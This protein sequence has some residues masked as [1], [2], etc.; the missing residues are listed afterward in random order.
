MQVVFSMLDLRD[1]SLLFEEMTF[2]ESWW[3]DAYHFFEDTIV[4]Q[5]YEDSNDIEQKT[6][7]ALNIHDH[8]IIWSLDKV[9]ATGRFGHYL[10]LKSLEAGDVLF[11][12]DVRNGETFSSAPENINDQLVSKSLKHP[13]LYTEESPFF[14]TI[15]AFGTKKLGKELVKGCHYLEH[16]ELVIMA[17]QHEA[18]EAV[19]QELVVLDQTSTI[20]LERVLHHGDGGLV[21]DAFFIAH[22]QLIFVEGK[23]TLNG[24]RIEN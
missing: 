18:P 17:Y 24:F 3:V 22:E 13:L 21:S 7:F 8:E 16:S 19:A 14:E 2:D 15:R 11:F 12:L 10:Q 20:L 9:V 6:Y 23:N 4:F 1:G 5:V